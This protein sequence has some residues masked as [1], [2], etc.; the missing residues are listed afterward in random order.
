M[1]RKCIKADL[2]QMYELVKELAIFEKEPDAVLTSVAEYETAYDQGLIDAF[3]AELNEE[4][5]GMSFFY[6]IFSTWNGRTLYLE[7]FVVKQSARNE[8]LGQKLFD[9]FIAEAKSQGCRQVKWQVLDWNEDAI[10]FYERNGASIEKNWWNGRM[11]LSKIV[12]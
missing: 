7:D 12:E 3:V 4:I 1:I 8:G 2:P 10:R 5:V 9:A 6:P 11:V